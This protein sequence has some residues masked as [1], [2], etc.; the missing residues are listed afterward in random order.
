MIERTFAFERKPV[1]MP[2][3]EITS[4]RYA[5]ERVE[6]VNDES[7]L[8]NCKPKGKTTLDNSIVGWTISGA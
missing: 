8:S 6:F 5:W 4:Q 7:K 3:D 2:K 1:F